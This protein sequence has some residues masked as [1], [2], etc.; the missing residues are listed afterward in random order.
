[1]QI[2]SFIVTHSASPSHCFLFCPA[3]LKTIIT[4]TNSLT[5]GA[6]IN[7][8][9]DICLN[10]LVQWK[11]YSWKPTSTFK[12]IPRTGDSFHLTKLW[13]FWLYPSDREDAKE[14]KGGNTKWGLIELQHQILGH[15]SIR[16]VSTLVSFLAADLYI[17]F[18]TFDVILLSHFFSLLSLDHWIWQLENLIM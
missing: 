1:M 12:N 15:Q 18:F 14:I 16:V 8:S 11:E 2:L 4:S 6:K 5:R 7:N 17:I 3:S 13:K 10:V 9:I